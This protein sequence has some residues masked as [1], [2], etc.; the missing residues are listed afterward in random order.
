MEC[1]EPENFNRILM[2]QIHTLS[3]ERIVEINVLGIPFLDES[4]KTDGLSESRGYYK[5]HQG[6]DER[7]TNSPC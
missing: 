1:V 4:V 6:W 2:H 5:P 3:A 7:T